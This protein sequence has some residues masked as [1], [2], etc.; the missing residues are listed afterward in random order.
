MADFCMQC[1]VPLGAPPGHSDFP[2]REG[3]PR[4]EL[5]EGCGFVLVDGGGRC[6]DPGCEEHG[7]T[8]MV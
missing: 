6:A 5:C 8:K 2:E 1:S 4:L 3:L 7:G